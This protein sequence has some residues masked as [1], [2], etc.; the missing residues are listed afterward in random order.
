LNANQDRSIIFLFDRLVLEV[1]RLASLD[2]V[3]DHEDEEVEPVRMQELQDAEEHAIDAAEKCNCWVEFR[4]HDLEYQLR[5]D[6]QAGPQPGR[7]HHCKYN[8][9]GVLIISRGGEF[10]HAAEDVCDIVQV[11]YR[12]PDS[13]VVTKDHAEIKGASRDVVKE[14]FVKIRGSLFEQELL[15]R[16]AEVIAHS[17][18]SVNQDGTRALHVRHWV[19][20][21]N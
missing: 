13:E 3:Q 20:S 9:S 18:E 5:Q 21:H 1:F 7:H 12:A 4:G 16:V 6:N 19:G 15:K 17:G 10:D 8:E 14:H 11:S 2:L